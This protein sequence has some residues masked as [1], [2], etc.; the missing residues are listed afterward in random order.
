MTRPAVDLRD[1]PADVRKSLGL[2]RQARRSMT[3]HEVRSYSIRVL[4]VMAD[5]QQSQRT[6][7]LRHALKVNDV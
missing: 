6:R 7:I 2:K 3:M 1:I 5:L 4:A